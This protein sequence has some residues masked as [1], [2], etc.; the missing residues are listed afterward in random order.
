MLFLDSVELTL[1]T[2]ET[3]LLSG[4]TLQLP[5]GH[6]SAIVGPSGC[7]KSTL[8]KTIAGIL[9]H[10]SGSIRWQNR[11]LNEEDLAPRELGYV[12]Q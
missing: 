5:G 10:T 11:D 6:F 4:I 9:P 8:L 3:P 12:P 2:A 1:T 7:G